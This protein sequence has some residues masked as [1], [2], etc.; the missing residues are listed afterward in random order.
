MAPTEK[1][2]SGGISGWALAWRAAKNNKPVIML[3]TECSA[4]SVA[5]AAHQPGS[6]SQTK[7]I[8]VHTCNQHMNR[9]DIADQC[10][11][12]YSFLCKRVSGGESFLGLQRQQ[13][14]TAPF[15]KTALKAQPPGLLM[16]SSREFAIRYLASAPPSCWI[17]CPCKCQHPE[18]SESQRLNWQLH[19][20]DSHSATWLYICM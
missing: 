10:A 9:V 8:V 3:S 19:L 17:V 5:V 2:W 4:R 1:W 6:E 15:S 13:W 7:L 16:C 14:W 12:Y 11:V 18:Q 20:I